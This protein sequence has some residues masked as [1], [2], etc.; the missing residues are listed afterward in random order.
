MPGLSGI[1]LRIK[2]I[3][4]NTEPGNSFLAMLIRVNFGIMTLCVPRDLLQFQILPQNQKQE[5][6][7]IQN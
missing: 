7:R 3:N 5:I 1:H 6:H 4:S 2:I